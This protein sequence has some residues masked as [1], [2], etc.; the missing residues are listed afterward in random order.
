MRYL[1][2]ETDLTPDLAYYVMQDED[3]QPEPMPTARFE[4]ARLSA[5]DRLRAI[6][7]S[8]P[9]HTARIATRR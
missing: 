8:F 7:R 9:T 6:L 3:A 1:A 2:E 5:Q 4:Q